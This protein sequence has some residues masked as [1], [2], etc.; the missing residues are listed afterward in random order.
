MS[1]DYEPDLNRFFKFCM[2]LNLSKNLNFL[3]YNFITPPHRNIIGAVSTTTK[4]FANGQNASRHAVKKI[5]KP[6]HEDYSY[7]IN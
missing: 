7:P 3:Q 5:A 1:F 6:E 2:A 4:T